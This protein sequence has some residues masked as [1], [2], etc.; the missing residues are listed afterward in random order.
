MVEVDYFGTTADG[1]EISIF[2]LKSEQ[3]QV[4]VINFGACIKSMIVNDKNG[5]PID[6]VLGFDTLEQYEKNVPYLGATI[7]RCTSRIASGRFELEGKQYQLPINN[8]ENSLHGGLIGFSHK[9][10][11]AEVLNENAV[12]MTYL[13]VDGEEGYPGNL[14]VS[15]TFSINK[16]QLKIDYQA[17]TDQTTI[18]NLTNHSY[19]NLNGKGSILDHSLQINSDKYLP[20]NSQSIL[21]GDVKSVD[22]TPFDFT[23]SKNLGRDIHTGHSMLQVSRGYD[24]A[25]LCQG[26]I[27]MTQAEANSALSGITLRVYTTEPTIH[28]YTGNFLDGVIGKSSIPYENYT[29]F[30][31]E[32]Q[33]PT[34]AINQPNFKS[35]IL[36][37]GE[38]YS[39]QTIFQLISGS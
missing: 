32:T 27:S 31:L 5:I 38:V 34:D 15:V 6:V 12:K 16:D 19:F 17:T 9:M 37:P 23:T 1:E 22:G 3:L 26:D 2:T 13:S 11:W 14:S 25:Y 4:D 28:L 7:G 8:G 29:G 20:L 10:W 30:C 33:Q 24:L 18:V 21:T 36:S 35:P 39:T